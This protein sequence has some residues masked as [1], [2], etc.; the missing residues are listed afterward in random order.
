MK[1]LIIF[2]I[3]AGFITSC[4]RAVTMQQAANRN[5]KGTRSVR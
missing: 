2:F 1:K 3:I 4:S 5:Y